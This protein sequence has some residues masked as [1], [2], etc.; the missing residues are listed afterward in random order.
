MLKTNMTDSRR[1]GMM[2]D[3][4]KKRSVDEDSIMAAEVLLGIDAKRDA[5]RLLVVA[6]GMGGHAKGEEASKMALSVISRTVMPRLLDDTPFTRLLEE[7][8]QNA[9]ETIL[10]H[11]NTYPETSGMGTTA[12]CAIINN[13]KVYLANIGDSRAY[14]ISQDEIRRVTKDHSY[15]QALIDDG[16]ISEDEAQVHPQKNIITKAIGASPTA[17]PDTMKLS[18][19][20]DEH[21]LLC[22][23]GVIAH[24]TD[25]DIRK[26]VLDCNDPQ[27]ACEN[28]VNMANKRGGTDNI[29][30]IILSS[31]EKMI[32]A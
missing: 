14:V 26:T 1:L 25:E 4:G 29:S 20:T 23:D 9:H 2:T 10:D 5:F 30:L 27:K 22:C 15:V 32:D 24:L 19:D 28:I 7:G 11:V 21:L 3:V 17:E 16:Q 13:S 6:D 12:V 8:I 31:E 18:L